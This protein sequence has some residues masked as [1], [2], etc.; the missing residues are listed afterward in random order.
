M[1]SN[2]CPGKTPRH[3]Q[4]WPDPTFAEAPTFLVNEAEVC[5]QILMFQSIEIQLQLFLFFFH[6]HL[7]LKGMFHW[8]FLQCEPC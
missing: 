2:S 1:H 5:I 6:L 3:S 7:W 8:Q 4:S